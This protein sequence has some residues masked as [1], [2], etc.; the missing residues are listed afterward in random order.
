MIQWNLKASKTG[1]YPISILE[2]KIVKTKKKRNPRTYPPKKKQKRKI[3][4]QEKTT[5][6]FNENS[7]KK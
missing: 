3:V 6:K 5:Q 1:L 7:K 4:N 2:Q